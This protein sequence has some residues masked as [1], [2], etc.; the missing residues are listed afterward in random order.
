MWSQ[1]PQKDVVSILNR[2]HELE[3]QVNDMERMDYPCQKCEALEQALKRVRA[4][5]QYSVLY[6]DNGDS[7]TFIWTDELEAAIKGVDDE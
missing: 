4:L 7:R 1:I 6:P 5:L 3:A 2:S